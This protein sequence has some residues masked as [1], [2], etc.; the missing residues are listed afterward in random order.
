M[1]CVTDAVTGG[2][3]D[4]SR[5]REGASLLAPSNSA[6]KESIMEVPV[7]DME[8][9]AL[10]AFRSRCEVEKVRIPATMCSNG[11]EDGV[12]LRFLRARKLDLDKA[13]KMLLA[14]LKWREENRVDEILDEALD[15]EDFKSMVRVYPSSYHGKDVHG[16]PVYIE[17]TGSAKFKEVL[18][19]LGHEVGRI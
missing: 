9:V 2:G 13:L 16:R 6:G 4:I 17:R 7:D 8:K 3:D 5:T 15:T 14:T 11:G 19:K 10:A 1:E 18:A 12:C